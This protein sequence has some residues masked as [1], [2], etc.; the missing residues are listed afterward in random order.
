MQRH[1]GRCITMTSGLLAVLFLTGFAY[2]KRKPSD[3]PPFQYVGGTENIQQGCGGKLEVL[4]DGLAFTCPTG[5]VNLPFSAI[6]LMQYRPDL[7]SQVWRMNI[8]WKVQP[9]HDKAKDNRYLTLVY[10][11]QDAIHAVVLR[12][13]PITMRPYLAEIELQSGKGVEVWRSYEEF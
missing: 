12:V 7:S 9:P 4:K 13:E 6:T 2:G 10:R 1:I 5:S 3:E 8:A 11:E